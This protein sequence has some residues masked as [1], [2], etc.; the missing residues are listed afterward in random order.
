MMK[1]YRCVAE[2]VEGF[3]NISLVLEH[4]HYL[5]KVAPS[6]QDH[7]MMVHFL[8]QYTKVMRHIQLSARLSN[9][10]RVE[11]AVQSFAV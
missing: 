3:L 1:R 11:H 9:N 2:T 7:M 6:H 10:L 5:T 4:S 8:V